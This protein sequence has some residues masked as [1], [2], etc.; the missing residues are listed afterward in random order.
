M[1]LRT[2]LL[3]FFGLLAVLPLLGMGVLHY[4]QSMRAVERHIGAQVELIAERAAAELVRRQ[5]L[6]MAEL[7]LLAENA[8]TQ[9]LFRALAAGSVAE[10][11]SARSGAAEFAGEVWRQMSPYY[12]AAELRDRA[13]SVVLQLGD[14]GVAGGGPE[15]MG[16]AAA[17]WPGVPPVLEHPILDEVTGAPLGVVLAA[18]R[19]SELL[20]TDAL[21]VRFGT[22]GYTLVLERPTGRVVHDSR[23]PRLPWGPAGGPAD[24]GFDPVSTV[25]AAPAGELTFPHGDSSRVAAFVALDGLPWTVVSV[26]ALDEFAAPFERMR[27]LNLAVVLLVILAVAAAS[28]LLVRRSTRSLEELTAAAG[29]VSRGEFLPSLP[30]S[31]PDE[32]GRLAAAFATM[33]GR[34]REMMTQLQASRQMAAVGEFAS[35]LAHEIRN[36]LTSVKLN[37][38]RI[39]RAVA[40][41][42]GPSEAEAPLRIALREVARLERVVRGVLHLG[43]PRPLERGV[44]AVRA[45]AGEALEVVRPEAEARGVRIETSFYPGADLV[46]ADADQLRGALL[47]LLLN[48][49]EAMPAGGE[50]RLTTGPL[51]E[52]PASDGDF[53]PGGAVAP[54]DAIALTVRYTGPGIPDQVREKLFRPFF[55]TKPE[56]TGL[57]LSVALRTAEEHGGQLELL[58]T[59]PGAGAAFRLV[60]PLLPSPVHAGATP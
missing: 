32:V 58:E 56:G 43:R 42:G 14:R 49:I 46:L 57:G 6:H 24:L 22:A 60:L 19:L 30:P 53:R 50:L 17:G 5:D 9:R 52:G 41:E 45:V 15:W 12:H 34:V 2:K 33:V 20:P 21:D 44:V 11:E 31:G 3:G 40:A 38:Q 35:E 4:V 55:T 39:D 29:D 23:G 16:G 51:S 47:N 36:P 27:A 13:G 18:P 59:A 1:S 8:E 37:L 7:V 26:A 28:V 10:L 48:G 54:R 25:F